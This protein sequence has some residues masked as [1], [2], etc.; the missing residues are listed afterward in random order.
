M[1]LYNE[2]PWKNDVFLN[3]FDVCLW[4]DQGC[5]EGRWPLGT[6][7]MHKAWPSKYDVES[8][9]PRKGKNM[10]KHSK[11]LISSSIHLQY[12]QICMHKQKKRV[13]LCGYVLACICIY[14][15][16]VCVGMGG[17]VQDRYAICSTSSATSVALMSVF[18]VSW[19]WLLKFQC[20]REP[21]RTARTE[22]TWTVA[23]PNRKTNTNGTEPQHEPKRGTDRQTMSS[24]QVSMEQ[25]RSCVPVNLLK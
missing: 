6:A 10:E 8:K 13:C 9:I 24:S 25:T 2:K 20:P 16:Y 12:M 4:I 15:Y 22:P 11:R 14:V 7:P 1:W 18:L 17:Y 3:A 5:Q 19:L 21:D 23:G